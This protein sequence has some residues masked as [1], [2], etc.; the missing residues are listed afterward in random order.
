M[1]MLAEVIDSLKNSNE[2]EMQAKALLLLEEAENAIGR[3]K[4]AKAPVKIG[5]AHV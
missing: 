3:S 4:P 2:G 1:K 5:R